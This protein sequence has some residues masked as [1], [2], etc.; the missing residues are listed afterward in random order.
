MLGAVIG[1]T[2][3]WI[4]IHI[5]F[6]ARHLIELEEN[7]P[8]VLDAPS[9]FS[10]DIWALGEKCGN[11]SANYAIKMHETVHIG[12]QYIGIYLITVGLSARTLSAQL[13]ESIM[14]SAKSEKKSINSNGGVKFLIPSLKQV[15]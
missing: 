8:L 15:L 13:H 12:L 11:L 1:W 6:F 4:S 5:K 7:S 9:P 14:R 2:A 10:A 3:R